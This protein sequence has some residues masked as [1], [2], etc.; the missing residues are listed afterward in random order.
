M[1]NTD[2]DKIASILI[3]FLKGQHSQEVETVANNSIDMVKLI[4]DVFPDIDE[5]V[6]WYFTENDWDDMIYY[7]KLKKCAE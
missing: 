4:L 1:T 2:R 7:L 3:Q 5:K 6:D